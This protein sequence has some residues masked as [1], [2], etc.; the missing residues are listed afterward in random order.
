MSE[1][2]EF[3][4]MIRRRVTVEGIVQ[5]VGF[6]PHVHRLARDLGLTGTALNVAGGL[7]VEIEG[8]RRAVEEFV[9]RI[10]AD[11]PPIAVIESVVVEELDPLGDEDF[12]IVPSR[13]GS[14]GEIYVSP[15]VAV[16][17]DCARELRDPADRH[18]AHPFVNCTNC[19]PRF[20]IV[21]GVPYD[22]PKTSMGAFPMCEA[23]RAEYEDIEDRRYH[24]QP[25]CCPECGP[26]VWFVTGD[27]RIEGAAAIAAAQNLLREGKIVAVKGL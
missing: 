23:C 5:G 20:T 3:E 7:E 1:T 24:A 25:V 18:H 9:R 12:A 15:D 22:R 27:R 2:P 10:E 11:A 8:P 17:A 13:G 19:G 26:T 16:C 21:E 14:E 6:R 4:T